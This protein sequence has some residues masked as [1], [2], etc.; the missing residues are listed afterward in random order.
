MPLQVPLAEERVLYLAL[1]LDRQWT[2]NCENSVS[3]PNQFDDE[4]VN[5]LESSP[6]QARQDKLRNQNGR[7]RAGR[8]AADNTY[9]KIKRATGSSTFE[10]RAY[11]V[12]RLPFWSFPSTAS[13]P[14]QKK[15]VVAVVE[16]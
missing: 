13:F 15:F 12:N 9:Q 5:L 6:R 4:I 11:G 16:F 8:R 7:L 10:V 1:E 14:S 3:R 2:E